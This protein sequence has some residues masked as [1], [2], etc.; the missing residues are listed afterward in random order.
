MDKDIEVDI[1]TDRDIHPV[2]SIPLE[3]RIETLTK[4]KKMFSALNIL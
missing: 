3:N 4:L 2:G 1:D